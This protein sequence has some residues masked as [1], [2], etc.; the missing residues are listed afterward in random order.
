M[1]LN[2]YLQANGSPRWLTWEAWQAGPQHEPVWTAI[3]Y[4]KLN[5]S[6]AVDSE[7]D[8]INL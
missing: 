3:A 2:N 4:S 1:Q 7:F 5:L 6:C 8:L